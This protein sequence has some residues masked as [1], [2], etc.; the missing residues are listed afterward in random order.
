MQR[1]LTAVLLTTILTA[2]ALAC[3]GKSARPY[4]NAPALAA[5][6]EEVLKDKP[7]GDAARARD[8]LREIR[9]LAAAGQEHEARAREEEAM[10]L[11]G[12]RKAYMRCG[13]GSFS[14]MKQAA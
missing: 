3:G 7:E 10:R 4:A 9:Q 14:W 12:Y 5:A 8:L 13:P 2:P 11:L 6:L 1:V